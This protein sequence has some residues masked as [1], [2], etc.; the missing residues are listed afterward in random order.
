[1]GRRQKISKEN[2]GS[3]AGDCDD[4][5]IDKKRTRIFIMRKNK[6]KT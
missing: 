6:N 2:R 5:K 4:K 1:M 3:K